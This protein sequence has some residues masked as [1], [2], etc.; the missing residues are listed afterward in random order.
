[1]YKMK[2]KLFLF[3]PALLLVTIAF[4]HEAILLASKYVIKKGETLELHLFIADGFNVDY[5]KSLE[6]NKI[7]TYRLITKEG[8]LDLKQSGM[9]NSLPIT[10]LKANFDG[11]GLFYMESAYS[12]TSLEPDKFREY[13]TEEHL[14]NISISPAETKPQK[15]RYSRY[16]KCLV[17]SDEIENDYLYKVIVG[18]EFEIILLQNPYKLNI[19]DRLQARV[20]F[21]G[22]PLADKTM[23]ARNRIGSLPPTTQI[24]KTDQQGVCEFEITRNGD[25][26][27]HG[28]HMIPCPEKEEADWESF[29]ASFSFGIK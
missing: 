28:T 21:Q 1:M 24:A 15:E 2:Q 17:Q 6:K 7:K 22:T 8:T 14:D 19:G 11:L 23:T 20:I 27:I 16:I 4:A 13:L 5:E 3:L 25:W 9:E 12:R 26:F 29:W 10:T 18:Q